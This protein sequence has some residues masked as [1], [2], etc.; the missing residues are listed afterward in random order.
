MSETLKQILYTAVV[1]L[2]VLGALWLGITFAENDTVTRIVSDFG[3]T[4]LFVAAIVSG[5]NVI[6]PIPLIA[7]VPTFVA[8]GLSFWFVVM[9]ITIGM[10]VGD[11]LGFFVGH[12]GRKLTE[13]DVHESKLA[14]WIVSFAD[15]HPRGAYVLLFFYATF[16]PVPNELIVVPMAFLGY[17]LRYM[18]PTVLVGNFIFNTLVS[19]GVLQVVALF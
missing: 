16:A 3:Y 18:A 15:K 12:S 1:I 17:K 11:A 7:F 13:P 8:S 2:V 5:F 19:L 6:I 4:G 10:T 9:V 14:R